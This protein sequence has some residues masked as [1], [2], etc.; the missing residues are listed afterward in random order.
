MKKEDYDKLCREIWD[1]NRHYY[2]EHSPIISDE[3]FDHLYKRFEEIEKVHPEWIT[4]ASP[5]QRVGES[6]TAGFKTVHHRTPMLSLANTYS[7]EELGDFISRMHKL[8]EKMSLAFCC[9][10]KMDGVAISAIYENGMFVQGITRGDGKKGDDVTANMRTIPSLPLKLYGDVPKLLEVRGEVFMPIKAFEKLNAQKEKEG[11]TLLANP[12]N[13]AAGALKLLD[14]REASKR[15]LSVVFYAIGEGSF[16]QV[17]SQYESHSLLHDLGLPTLDYRE[18]CHS[19]DQIFGFAEKI[20][21]HRSKLSYQIDG[22]VIKLDDIQEH[23]RLGTTGKNP[24]WAVAYKFAAEQAVTK[25][26]DIVVQVGRTGVCTPVAELE[27]V[28]VAGSTVSRATLHNQEEVA[29]KD[30]RVADI[31]TIEKGGDVIPKV[32]CVDFKQ[33]RKESK[34]WKML[35]ECPE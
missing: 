21:G 1:H 25:I 10:L 11:E 18:K 27:P 33:R 34:P 8:V 32:V 4:P 12:R 28:F 23:A 24:R 16:V 17:T 7:R 6:L 29:R 19:L 31:V 14:P 3:E 5:T 13:A 26:L 22:I 30:I 20:R 9:E 2:I 15:K 35:E